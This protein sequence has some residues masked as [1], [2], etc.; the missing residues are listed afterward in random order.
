MKTQTETKSRTWFAG[1]VDPE[2][3]KD[4]YHG[5]ARA[6]HPDHGGDTATMQEIN[7]QYDQARK[8]LEA[9]APSRK[10][11]PPQPNKSTEPVSQEA[12]VAAVLARHRCPGVFIEFMG[13]EVIA[14][15]ASYENREELKKLGFWWDGEQRYWHYVRKPG[16]GRKGAA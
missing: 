7:A 5:L 2:Q 16:T 10:Y 12:A 13:G 14:R 6:Y 15:G 8:R 1:V 4:L 11:S 9:P 3:L